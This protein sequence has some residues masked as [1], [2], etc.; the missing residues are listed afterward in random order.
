MNVILLIINFLYFN[1]NTQA[2][3]L[4]VINYGIYG[5]NGEHLKK[6]NRIKR[7]LDNKKFGFCFQFEVNEVV[8]KVTMNFGYYDGGF[9]ESYPR[10]VLVTEKLAKGCYLKEIN[11]IDNLK[12]SISLSI[13]RGNNQLID[14]EFLLV[15]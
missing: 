7:S 11:K 13:D 4:K 6:T 12:K 3:E 1:L 14:M 15:D 5:S 10:Y 8:D 2:Y 9:R